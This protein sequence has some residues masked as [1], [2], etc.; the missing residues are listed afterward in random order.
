[1]KSVCTFRPENRTDPWSRMSMTLSWA[2]MYKDSILL[3]GEHRQWLLNRADATMG[4]N[5]LKLLQAVAEENST[6]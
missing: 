5:D 3:G 2:C 1:M 6:S 4:H